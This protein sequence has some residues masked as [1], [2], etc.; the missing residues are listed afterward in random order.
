MEASDDP[1]SG[2]PGD[3]ATGD[4]ATGDGAPHALA[5]RADA[6]LREG[7]ALLRAG[8][9]DEADAAIGAAAGLHAQRGAAVDEARCLRLRAVLRRLQGRLDDA[10]ESAEASLSLLSARGAPA[11][12][13][14][15]TR[16]ELGEIAF[17]RGDAEAAVRAWGAAI[18][19]AGDAAPAA[20]WR[21]RGRAHAL[22]GRFEAAAADLDEAARRGEAAGDAAGA[23]RAG[24]EA[25]VAWQRARRFDRADELAARARPRAEA[26]HDAAALADLELVSAAGALERGDAA[27]A[28][29]H[30]LA[31]RGHA[32]AA[33]APAPYIGAAVAL[34]RLD[35]Q[36]GDRVGAYAALAAGWATLGDLLGPDLAR[37]TFEPLLLRLRGR[38]SA[39]VFDETRRA[40]EAQRRAAAAGEAP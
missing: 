35:E 39:A 29:R 2:A 20:W 19:E 36:A 11:A 22:A 27:A 7:D 32:L 1:R 26:A 14:A 24:V 8:R 25:A 38:W 34:S 30:A 5:A 4:G 31:A 28:R 3:G 40:Y 12:E 23:L 9:L 17:A 21:G 37:A 18:G 16:A 33:R 13:A 10:S 6:L 15:A